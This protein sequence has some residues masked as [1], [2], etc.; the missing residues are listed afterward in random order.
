MAESLEAEILKQPYA[1]R[2]PP[3]YLHIYA[4][5]RN[6]IL[7]LTKPN[8]NVMLSLSCGHLGFRK[9]GRSGYDPAFQL[10][11]HFFAQ[12]HERA[13]ML[14]IKRLELVFRDFGQGRE[15]FTKVLMGNEGK[16]VRNAVV[17]VTDSTRLKFGGTKSRHVRRLG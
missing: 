3:H 4:H 12:M 6:T 8:G 11:S 16:N 13:Y 14:E 10:T 5:R 2:A 7:T 1:D 15:A 9:S 17:S